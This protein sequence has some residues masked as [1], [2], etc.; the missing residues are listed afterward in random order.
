VKARYSR[1]Y[2]ITQ[3][4]L[5][6]LMERATYVIGQIDEACTQHISRLSHCDP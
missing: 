3:E 1:H 6:W 2:T 5:A 4:A